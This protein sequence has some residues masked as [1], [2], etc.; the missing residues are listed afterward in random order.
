MGSTSDSR[1]SVWSIKLFKCLEAFD[2][3][4]TQLSKAILEDLASQSPDATFSQD[5]DRFLEDNY[6]VQ[7]QAIFSA[8][9]LSCF[10]SH[11][12]FG[13]HI[14]EIG[15]ADNCTVS[16]VVRVDLD[17][18][19][20]EPRFRFR[21]GGV[22]SDGAPIVRVFLPVLD[23]LALMQNDVRPGLDNGD[24]ADFSDVRCLYAQR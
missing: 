2:L 12:R 14:H 5:L 19:F 16:N 21:A 10:R 20:I 15:E 4:R 22:N 11:C 17:V 13:D 23:V 8:E 6:I 9:P 24:C 1:F 18:T 3:S 7:N